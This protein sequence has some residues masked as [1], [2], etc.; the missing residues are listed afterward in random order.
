MTTVNR[1]WGNF[2]VLET[3]QSFQVKHLEVFPSSRLSLQSHQFR[4]EHW[5][6]VAGIA[7]V[8]VDGR[9]LVLQPGESV[10]IPV[11]SRH[12]VTAIGDTSLVFIEIQTGISFDESDIV[13]YEDDYGRV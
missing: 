12:R 10:Q 9:V 13:R 3:Q 5:F 7:Q 11:K 6:V 2:K 1:P 8:E 4:S